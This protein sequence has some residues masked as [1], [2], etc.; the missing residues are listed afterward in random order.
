MLDMNVNAGDDS[1]Y[2]KN[3]RKH[4]HNTT[5]TS[6]H[7][8]LVYDTLQCQHNT[9]TNMTHQKLPP[10]VREYLCFQNDRK[11]PRKHSVPNKGHWLKLLIQFFLLDNLNRNVPSSKVYFIR[12]N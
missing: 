3:P 4:N 8:S 6:A 9:T 12:N 11:M 1:Q 7:F 5:A 10:Y 2:F